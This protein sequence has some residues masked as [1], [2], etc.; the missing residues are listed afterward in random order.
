MPHGEKPKW[1]NFKKEP[2][3]GDKIDRKREQEIRNHQMKNKRRG[4]FL[5]GPRSTS[6]VC[7]SRDAGKKG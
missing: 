3:Y 2:L 1:G 4:L 5:I 6:T 7:L